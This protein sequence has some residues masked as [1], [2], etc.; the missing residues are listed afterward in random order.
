[1]SDEPTDHDDRVSQLR[2]K[3]VQHNIAQIQAQ[4]ARRRADA[5]KRLIAKHGQKRIALA[6]SKFPILTTVR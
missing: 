5:E 3:R 4:F 2:R 6:G 1:M